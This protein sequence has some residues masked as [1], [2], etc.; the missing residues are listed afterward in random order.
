[1]K[2]ILSQFKF[3]ADIIVFGETKLKASFPHSIYNMIGYQRLTCCRNAANSGGGLMIF[4]KNQIKLINVD[5]HSSSFE[6][7]SLEIQVDQKRYSLLLYYRPPDPSNL[8]SFMDDLEKEISSKITR[9][10]IAGDINIDKNGSTKDVKEYKNLLSSYNFEIINNNP[11]RNASMKIIDH[12]A[13]NF[14]NDVSIDNY[15]IHNSLSDHNLIIT[16]INGTLLKKEP[17]L[18]EFN[19]IDYKKVKVEFKIRK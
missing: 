18:K 3:K 8:Q 4:I 5:S 13:C 19:Q 6:R 9:T 16:A 15:T 7:L 17:I 2:R 10:I 1:M 11:T 12:M 14:K